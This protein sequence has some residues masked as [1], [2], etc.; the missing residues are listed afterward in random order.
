[1]NTFTTPLQVERVGKK[2]WR[3]LTPL[4]YGPYTVP[5]GFRT[6]F[7]SVPRIP[8]AYDWLGNR[9]QRAGTVHDWLYAT[10]RLPRAEADR[11]LRKMVRADGVGPLGAFLMYAAVRLFGGRDYTHPR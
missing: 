5:A 2:T 3:L 7:C 8:F 1:V 4:T 9:A 6:D 11:L 10:R